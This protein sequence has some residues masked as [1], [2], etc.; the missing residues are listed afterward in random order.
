VADDPPR[1]THTIE[2]PYTRT[3]GPVYGAFL[4]GL[5]DERI[6]GIR[7]GDGRVLCPPTEW[8]PE[9]GDALD[10]DLVE[11]GP[12]GVVETWAWV[13]APTR[14]HP[15]DHPFAFALIR[16]DGADTALLHAVDA[17]SMDAMHTGM[18]VTARWKPER[19]GHIAD[20]AFVPEETQR[21]AGRTAG[22]AER[23]RPG[24]QAS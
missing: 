6:L 12:G 18:R 7:A 15:L 5:R 13:T 9:T 3:L 17:G 10:H 8:D 2:F 4:T 14:K 11:V 21:S 1:T 22:S 19:L 16:L 20:V 23:S 24:E